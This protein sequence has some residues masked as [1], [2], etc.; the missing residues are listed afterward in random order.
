MKRWMP[1]L[2]F[3]VTLSLLGACGQQSTVD[4]ELP[5]DQA[6][7]TWW[8]E[9]TTQFPDYEYTVTDE[10]EALNTLT[11]EV[12]LQL[13]PS[14]DEARDLIKRDFLIEG[15]AQEPE[16][17]VSHSKKYEFH[18]ASMI[19]FKTPE[20]VYL[21]YGVVNEDYRYI[22]RLGK[23]K[24]YKQKIEV[25]NATEN[26]TY[27]GRSLEATLVSLGQLLK[28]E[29]PEQ[30]VADFMERTNDPEKLKGQ[31]VF[32]YDTLEEAADERLF[33]IRFGVEYNE[34]G[35]LKMIYAY[36]VDNRI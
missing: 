10:E 18:F 9:R 35:V 6:I 32:I 13:L 24:L 1:V 22:E 7:F 33:G 20:G 36:T 2:V 29:E 28:L 15:T 25:Y 19:K 17:F 12:G 3:A 4:E 26:Q 14:F 5:K 31:D 34:E 21:S 23:V 16:E 30:L 27:N 11:Q 8:G